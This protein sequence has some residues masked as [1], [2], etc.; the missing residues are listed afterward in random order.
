MKKPTAILCRHCRQEIVTRPRGLGWRCFYTPGVRD[1]YAPHP[2]SHVQVSTSP[3]GLP[4]PTTTLPGTPERLAVLADRAAA[5]LRL[6]NPADAV[7][8]ET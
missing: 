4:E 3:T 2:K 7:H 8:E 6:W 1:M 5:G